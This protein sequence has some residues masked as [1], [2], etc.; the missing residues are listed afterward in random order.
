MQPQTDT[1]SRLAGAGAKPDDLSC[2]PA[3]QGGK[4]VH[5]RYLV[6]GR[7]LRRVQQRLHCTEVIAAANS[8][9]AG[10]FT[11]PSGYRH[12]STRLRRRSETR[13]AATQGAQGCNS[14]TGGIYS[15]LW[16][17]ELTCMYV[18][19]YRWQ[20]IHD[21]SVKSP[22]WFLAGPEAIPGVVILIFTLT[23]AYAALDFASASHYSALRPISCRPDRGICRHHCQQQ[24][25]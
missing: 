13:T 18:H 9:L 23:S 5:M 11:P 4:R 2:Y 19:E 16:M 22:T 6:H 1:G 24:A 10:C 3:G 15:A 21:A 12:T 20:H 8:I 14:T 17:Q 25:V 7:A